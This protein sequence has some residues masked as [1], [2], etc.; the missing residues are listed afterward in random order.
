[1]ERLLKSN[2]IKGSANLRLQY[3]GLFTVIYLAQKR[4][5]IVTTEFLINSLSSDRAGTLRLA[6]GLIKLGL[7]KRIQILAKHGKGRTFQF[8]IALPDD[9]AEDLINEYLMKK[10]SVKMVHEP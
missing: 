6:R 7:I 9:M 1:M 2:L 8:E 10:V 4:G 3:I 5:N